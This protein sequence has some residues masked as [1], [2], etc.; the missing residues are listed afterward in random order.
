MLRQWI[1]A[2]AILALPSYA[3]A[4]A[5]IG[6]QGCVQCRS[7]QSYSVQSSGVLSSPVQ[8]EGVQS[9]CVQCG[10]VQCGERPTGFVAAPF[11]GQV[12]PPTRPGGIVVP[13]MGPG[14]TSDVN[15]T[16]P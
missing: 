5:E 14:V 6:S 8:S 9:D 11:I 15:L 16:R 4:Q 3:L 2:A 1:L 13:S 12:A 10:C 7:V